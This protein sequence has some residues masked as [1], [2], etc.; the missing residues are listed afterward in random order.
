LKMNPYTPEAWRTLLRSLIAVT[1]G[2]CQLEST[3]APE[4]DTRVGSNHCH[5][6]WT[7]RYKRMLLTQLVFRIKTTKGESTRRETERQL[8]SLD[9]GI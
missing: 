7:K 4:G 9:K 3:E 1:F 8:K 2:A 5:A 6:F